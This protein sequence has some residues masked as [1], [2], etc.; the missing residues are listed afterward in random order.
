MNR[1]TEKTAKKGKDNKI[2]KVIRKFL[3][4]TRIVNSIIC[5]WN[6]INEW[7]V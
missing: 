3:S 7:L 5:I 1:K 2:N 4:A 6:I